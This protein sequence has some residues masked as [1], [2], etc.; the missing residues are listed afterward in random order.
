[1]VYGCS[2]FN[3]CIQIKLATSLKEN[4]L[5]WGDLAPAPG[6]G[7]LMHQ[8]HTSCSI[9][10]KVELAG[11]ILGR[12]VGSDR[13]V[14]KLLVLMFSSALPFLSLYICIPLPH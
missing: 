12:G 10:L 4:Y 3:I 9:L 1:M 8:H 6:T 7:V 5:S 14:A 13:E 11:M 2:E